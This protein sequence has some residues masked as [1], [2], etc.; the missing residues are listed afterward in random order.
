MKHLALLLA[1]LLG[2]PTLAVAQ[3]LEGVWLGTGSRIIGGANDGQVATF[4][5]PRLLIYTK[6]HFMW[7]FALGEQP[8]A[9]LPPAAQTSDAQLAAAVQQYQSTAGTY[10]RDGVNII[11]NRLV[12]M[13]PNNMEPGNQPL[14]R[15]IRML[16]ADRLE[17]Q[18]TNA[19]SVTTVLIYR[20]VE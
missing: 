18:V 16:T 9:L 17:T 10:M 2:T 7:A 1:L 20:R 11:Y 5:Q 8:R 6:A 15:Q 13:I 12:D 3:S 19:D 14:V 4:S